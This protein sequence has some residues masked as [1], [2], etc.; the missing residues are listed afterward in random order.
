MNVY[1]KQTWW[2]SLTLLGWVLYNRIG[3]LKKFLLH[4]FSLSSIN[5]KWALIVSS[6]AYGEE[7]ELRQERR[8]EDVLPPRWL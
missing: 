1:V 7:V 4:R 3:I 2:S 5:I 8:K 6:P